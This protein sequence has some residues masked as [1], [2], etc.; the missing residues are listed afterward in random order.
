MLSLDHD[1]LVVEVQL[2]DLCF[3]I[4][5][6]SQRSR[7]VHADDFPTL[8]GYREPTFSDELKVAPGHVLCVIDPDLI[9]RLTKRLNK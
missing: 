1:C 4:V 6:T 3:E 9:V 7:P 2:F 8:V 5:A